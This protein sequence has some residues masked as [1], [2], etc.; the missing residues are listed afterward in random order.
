MDILP[1]VFPCLTLVD[2]IDIMSARDQSFSVVFSSLNQPIA[3][4]FTQTM[5]ILK[6]H[7]VHLRKY[8]YRRDFS[9][10]KVDFYTNCG[11]ILKTMDYD[12]SFMVVFPHLKHGSIEH[13]VE[14][15]GLLGRSSVR[16]YQ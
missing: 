10:S 4:F 13:S 15:M 12:L 9:K 6:T 1:D 16:C 2:F 7:F 11:E 8:V 14:N 3:G 5:A